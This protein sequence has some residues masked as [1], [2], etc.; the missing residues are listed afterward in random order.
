MKTTDPPKHLSAESKALWRHLQADYKI[1][2]AAGLLLLRNAL[3]AHD[4]LGEARRILKKEGCVVTDRWGQR[5]QHPAT[6]VEQ[7]ARQQLL[8]ALR[9]LKLEPGVVQ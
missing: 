5:K 8:A 7:S 2:D 6:L 4:R 9:G 1:D 3:E